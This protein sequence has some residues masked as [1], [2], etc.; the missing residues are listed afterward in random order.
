MS[1]FFVVRFQLFLCNVQIFLVFL[2]FSQISNIFWVL[3]GF[4]FVLLDFCV[5]GIAHAQYDGQQLI[6]KNFTLI[7]WY[8]NVVN[9]KSNKMQ[10]D[11]FRCRLIIL[12][13][14]DWIWIDFFETDKRQNRKKSSCKIDSLDLSET[15]I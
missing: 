7:L 9:F 4:E 10:N 5:L 6:N 1:V 2:L 11:I 14:F 15:F 12:K 13:K 8:F 3:R